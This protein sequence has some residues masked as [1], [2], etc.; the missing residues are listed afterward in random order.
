MLPYLT[1]FVLSSM[2]FINSLY[3]TYRYRWFQ[4]VSDGY[5]LS[6]IYQD[7][8]GVK[9]RCC[10]YSIVRTHEPYMLASCSMTSLRKRKYIYLGKTDGAG[11]ENETDVVR[12]ED[13]CVLHYVF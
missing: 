12:R 2:P 11:A 9:G 8:F 5:G 1:L 4:S 10:L 7:R 6:Q 3:N 13:E